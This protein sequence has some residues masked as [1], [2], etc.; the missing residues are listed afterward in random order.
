[1]LNRFP[2]EQH[3]E[4]TL[5]QDALPVME[6]ADPELVTNKMMPLA[7][8]QYVNFDLECSG[9]FGD[10]EIEAAKRLTKDG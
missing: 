3:Q 1:V 6:S 2:F 4:Q 9:L 10:R 5:D 7:V 8:S